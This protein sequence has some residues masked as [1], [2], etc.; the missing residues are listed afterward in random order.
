[1]LFQCAAFSRINGITDQSCSE[2]RTERLFC[3]A[4]TDTGCAF[5]TKDENCIDTGPGKRIYYTP[6]HDR[7][8][9]INVEIFFLIEIRRNICHCARQ[10]IRM[11]VH[12]G[13]NISEIETVSKRTSSVTFFKLLSRFFYVTLL[14]SQLRSSQID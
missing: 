4:F 9:G 8:T 6:R 2:N 10:L 12:N 1:M 5:Q 13:T 3:H 7:R 14:L 11:F